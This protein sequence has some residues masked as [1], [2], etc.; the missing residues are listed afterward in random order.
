MIVMGMV[1]LLMAIQTTAQCIVHHQRDVSDIVYLQTTA[2]M[3]DSLRTNSTMCQP[4]TNQSAI[5]SSNMRGENLNHKVM[6][7]VI[8]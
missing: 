3:L 7:I 4:N 1:H 2:E 6:P 8:I 5:M